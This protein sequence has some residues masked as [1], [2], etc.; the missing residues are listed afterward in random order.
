MLNLTFGI[1]VLHRTQL[2]CNFQ[3]CHELD[4]GTPLSQRF[5]KNALEVENILH[6]FNDL[7]IGPN[8]YIQVIAYLPSQFPFSV[9]IVV[10]TQV[11][12]VSEQEH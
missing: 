7:K 10:P 9:Q 4:L 11:F 1:L 6:V 8:Y 12:T 2:Q 3:C 5:H